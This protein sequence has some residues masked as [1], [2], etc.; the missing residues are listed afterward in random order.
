MPQK[1]VDRLTNSVDPDIY[2][3]IFRIFTVDGNFSENL[4]DLYHLQPVS[5]CTVHTHFLFI[6]LC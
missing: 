5:C 1:D 4:P 2:V 3:P 6:Q